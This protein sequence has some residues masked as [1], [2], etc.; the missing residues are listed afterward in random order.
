M[1]LL[2]RKGSE[3]WEELGFHG[4]FTER[5][6]GRVGGQIRLMLFFPPLSPSIISMVFS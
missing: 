5:L 2:R 1:L 4:G 6:D 3:M